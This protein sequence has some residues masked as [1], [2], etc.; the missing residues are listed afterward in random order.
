MH[1]TDTVFYADAL[2]HMKFAYAPV[3]PA[4]YTMFCANKRI[5]K[6]RCSH[7]W[8]NSEDGPTCRFCNHHQ[9]AIQC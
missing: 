3:S 1:M 8:E 4:L 2:S 5:Q 6:A 7:Q 9:W